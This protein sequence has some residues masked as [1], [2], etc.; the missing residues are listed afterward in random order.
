[1][2]ADL[3]HADHLSDD[4]PSSACGSTIGSSEAVMPGGLAKEW[5]WRAKVGKGWKSAPR[6]W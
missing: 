1:M 6:T 5:R 3:F 4:D 2:V